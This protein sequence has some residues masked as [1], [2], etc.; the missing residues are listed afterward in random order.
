[1][2]NIQNRA[3]MS[4]SDLLR[5]LLRRWPIIIVTIAVC[6]GLGAAMAV[7]AP[8]MYTAT[9][10]LTVSPI[11]TNP[12]SSAAVN[13]QINITTER[14]ILASGEVAAIAAA[15]LGEKVSSGTLQNSSETA[16]PSGSQ[17]LQ[18]S[19]TLPDAAKAA[20][21]AN[22][23]AEAYL[24]FRS[25]GA[26]DVAAGFI[27]QLDGRI[28][29]F[30]KLPSLTEGQR[31][32]LEDLQLQRTSLNLAS[33]NPGRV[34]GYATKP[35]SQSSMGWAVFLTSGIVGGILL[36][37]A[38]ALVR[39][40]SDPRVRNAARQRELFSSDVVVL[41]GEQQESLR[42][43]VR[44]IRLVTA[45]DPQE[46]TTFVGVINLPGSGPARLPSFLAR[47]T[48]RHGLETSI[49]WERDI[50][51]D[52]VDLGWPRRGT[53]DHREGYDMVFVET[54]LSLSPSRVADLSNRMDVVVI[55]VGRTTR[56][57]R[58][59]R[60]ITLTRGVPEDRIIP[61]FYAPDKASRS[62][63]G[64]GDGQGQVSRGGSRPKDAVAGRAEQGENL[65]EQAEV[66]AVLLPAAGGLNGGRD[67]R[68]TTGWE[69]KLS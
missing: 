28:K 36:G 69:G 12:F 19:V 52:E 25:Q 43:L 13:Q 65:D 38:L 32:Q 48:K 26:A 4:I 56:L 2:A 35:S 68:I 27:E 23:L 6:A 60:T 17:I 67:A 58:L 45:Q 59:K 39:E 34:I 24:Q 46:E 61:V 44:T 3:S 33:T 66:P 18:V 22:A 57:A 62:Q 1:M 51:A 37:L 49:V 64:T 16:A 7:V 10:S 11:T 50:S 8:G 47:L 20:N 54:G 55:V 14:A 53:D 42:W 29:N 21:Q 41:R 40:I 31:Q 5:K 15:E 30:E 9:A 63:R